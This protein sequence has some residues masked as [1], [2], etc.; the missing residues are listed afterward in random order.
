MNTAIIVGHGLEV[1]ALLKRP[2]LLPK[3]LILC[4]TN[5]SIA[6]KVSA[7]L[8]AV[9][10]TTDAEA[11]RILSAWKVKRIILIGSLKLANPDLEGGASLLR[12]VERTGKSKNVSDAIKLSI[13]DLLSSS[14]EFP[15]AKSVLPFLFLDRDDGVNCEPDLLAQALAEPAALNGCATVNV[16]GAA[17]KIFKVDETG[18][19]NLFNCCLEPRGLRRLHQEKSVKRIFFDR[20]RTIVIDYDTMASYARFH[21]LTLQSFV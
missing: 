9:D 6:P 17:T 4:R 8:P 21:K 15:A 5:L 2:D 7:H 3:N 18:E 11:R 13:H 14:F 19:A 16:A 10:M 20:N 1:G 12:L